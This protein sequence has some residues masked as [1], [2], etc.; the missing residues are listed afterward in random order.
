MNPYLSGLPCAD[1]AHIIGM[2][3]HTQV[4]LVLSC[5][6][7]STVH[8]LAIVAPTCVQQLGNSLCFVAVHPTKP[9]VFFLRSEYDG[10]ILVENNIARTLE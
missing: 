10:V 6:R 9:L 1:N 7:S 5:I 2:Y 4:P 3:T 8:S